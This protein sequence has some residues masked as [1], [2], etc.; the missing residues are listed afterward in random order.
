[1]K[2]RTG[3]INNKR[4]LIVNSRIIIAK[5][6]G[7]EF[8]YMLMP[9]IQFLKKFKELAGAACVTFEKFESCLE[10]CRFYTLIKK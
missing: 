9:K 6:Y 8:P 10:Y 7:V 4:L 5:Q 2:L 1:M 3:R